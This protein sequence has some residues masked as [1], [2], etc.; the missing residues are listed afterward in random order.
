MTRYLSTLFYTAFSVTT[1][2]LAGCATVD[3]AP[4]YRRSVELTEQATGTRDLYDMHNAEVVAARVDALLREGLTATE[5]VEIALLHNPDLQASF[6]EIGMARADLVQS[7]LLSNPTLGMAFRLPAGGGLTAIDMDIAQ[8]IA[9]LWQIPARKQAAQRNLDYTILRI[10]CEASELAAE[11]KQTYYAAI[12]ATQ[13]ESIVRENLK[14]TETTL[15][16]SEYQQEAGAGNALDVNLARGTVLEAQLAVDQARLDAADAKRKLAML[17]GLKI[18]AS[19]LTLIDEPPPDFEPLPAEAMTALAFTHRLD[20]R[21]MHEAE[22]A[23]AARLTLEYRR[24]F[25]T[26]EIG[27]SMEREARDPGRGRD[28]WADTARSSIAAGQLSAPEIEPR[29]ARDTGQDVTLGPG[30]SLELPVFD[31]NQA[32]IARAQYEW[33]QA[34]SRLEALEVTIIQEVHGAIDQAG[35]ARHIARFYNQQV[36]P[37]AERNLE[38]ARASYKAGKSSFLSVLDAER[39]YLSARRK[40]AAAHEQAAAALARL[41]RVIGRPA[42]RWDTYND[43]DI[44]MD[45]Q[46]ATEE[47]IP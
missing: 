47:A 7:G 31:Q 8:N 25:P 4:D 46:P 19:R 3:P 12:H 45:T 38:F 44:I 39:T 28:I 16:L 30:F 27:L 10:A 5:A 36:L 1:I 6:K 2:V 32:Q 11:V 15:E 37:Q 42:N 29:S 20:Y 43:M 40:K 18:E 22:R 23:A 14:V 9:D 24:I 34:L 35:S 33:Q 41:E 21:A 26:L 17:L 13:Q